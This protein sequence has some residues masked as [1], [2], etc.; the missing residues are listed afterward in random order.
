MAKFVE[1]KDNTTRRWINVERIASIYLYKI[2]KVK[3]I[4]FFSHMENEITF[5]GIE[6]TFDT[7]EEAKKVIE[8]LIGEEKWNIKSF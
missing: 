7:E 4:V 1:I 5:D 8:K 2:S 6:L 3:V